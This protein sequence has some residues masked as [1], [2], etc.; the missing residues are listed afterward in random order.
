[1]NVIINQRKPGDGELIGSGQ[2][3]SGGP[4]S[5]PQGPDD[6]DKLGRKANIQNAVEVVSRHD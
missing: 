6:G 4:P 3:G 5:G 1:M 2:E